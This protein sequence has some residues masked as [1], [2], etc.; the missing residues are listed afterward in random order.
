[1]CAAALAVPDRCR[2]KRCGAPAADDHA[3]LPLHPQ[4]YIDRIMASGTNDRLARTGMPD[5][6]MS[7]ARL[8]PRGVPWALLCGSG[9]CHGWRY[10]TQCFRGDTAPRPSN[11]RTW[12]SMGFALF[13]HCGNRRKACYWM[14]M[15]CRGS[16]LWILNVTTA[17]RNAGHL[18]WTNTSSSFRHISPPLWPEPAPKDER[19]AP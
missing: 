9:C 17:E 12:T 6:H 10:R 1:M 5:T 4:T 16:Q 14:C 15:A 8:P 18:L 13:G 19:G 11:R 7:K 2:L 3:I